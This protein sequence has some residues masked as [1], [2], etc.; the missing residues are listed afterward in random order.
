VTRVIGT[1]GHIDHGKTALVKALS[2]Q[3]TDRLAAEKARGISID[4]GFA[5]FTLPGG[6]DVAVIDV[7]GHERFIRN[8]VAGAHGIDLVLF[9]IAADDGV[10]PQSEEHFTIVCALGVRHAIFVVTKTDAVLPDRLAEVAAEI[11]LLTEGTRHAGAAVVPVSNVTG[12]GIDTL[13]AAIAKTLALAAPRHSDRPFRMPIDR[14]FSVQGRGVVV[15]GTALAGRVATD[16]DL[17]CVP[18]GRTCRVRGVQKHGQSIA[19]GQSG[20]RLAINIAGATTTDFHR[21]DV[22]CDA[23]I[24]RATTRFDAV[25]SQSTGAAA[26]KNGQRLRLHVGAAE[27]LARLT[28]LGGARTLVAGNSGLA[29]LDLRAPVHAMSGDLFVLRDEQGEHTLGGGRVLDPCAPRRA[30]GDSA[31]LIWLKS[32]VAGDLSNAARQLID[33]CGTVALRTGDLG[34]R[35][36][37]SPDACDKMIKG[38]QNLIAIDVSADAWVTTMHA[39]QT[40]ATDSTATLHRFHQND[41][42]LPGVGIDALQAIVAPRA[43]KTVFRTLMAQLT[44]EGRLQRDGNL[45]ALPGHDAAL[46]GALGARGDALLAMLERS[47]FAPLQ[48]DPDDAAARRLIDALARQGKV[49]RLN[50]GL[51]FSAKAYADV[52]VCLEDFLTEHGEISVGAFRDLLGTTRKYALALLESFDRSGRTVRHGDVRK[53]GRPLNKPDA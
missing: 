1:A 2:G 5:H 43:E 51:A 28:I 18:G 48:P 35:L 39:L 4:L 20:D 32:I 13:K 47:P 52:D 8:M 44:T 46:K 11:D 21:G 19:T 31:R 9:V 3:D 27:R 26:L 12:D 34:F 29:Q 15:T 33:A 30:R 36:N 42:T 22:L 38:D 41:P 17:A 23:S 50:G 45:L 24:A 40:L 53:R 37:L 14:V 16:R 7:P 6:S 49:L 10:M 25:I